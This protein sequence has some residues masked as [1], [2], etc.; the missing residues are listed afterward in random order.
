MDGYCCGCMGSLDRNG[1][2]NRNDNGNDNRN[3]NG[4][5]NGNYSGNVS[6]NGNDCANIKR[7]ERC[8]FLTKIENLNPVWFVAVQEVLSYLHRFSTSRF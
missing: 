2:D 3:D 7:V 8:N 1:D 4:Y 6:N 5:G